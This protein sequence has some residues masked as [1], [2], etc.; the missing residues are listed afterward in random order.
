MS[1]HHNQIQLR[2]ASVEPR[3]LKIGGNT[4]G[5]NTFTGI[6]VSNIFGA[7]Y[8]STNLL[9]ID[10]LVCFFYRLLLAVLPDMLQGGVIGSLLQTGLSLITTY[11]L[12][13]A[14]PVCPGIGTSNMYLIDRYP[15]A[16]VGP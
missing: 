11:I 1:N 8:S 2:M 12:P 3:L 16:G 6:D 14:N 4:N 10:R 13:L 9:N 5:V 7:A 15:G